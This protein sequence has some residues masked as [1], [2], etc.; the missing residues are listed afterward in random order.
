MVHLFPEGKFAARE[1]R[2]HVKET[3]QGTVARLISSMVTLKW[4]ELDEPDVDRK[5]LGESSNILKSVFVEAFHG[6]TIQLDGD[7]HVYG[8]VEGAQNIAEICQVAL[9]LIFVNYK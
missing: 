8:P 7:S 2:V 5:G 1:Q 4:H 6:N 3:R 9:G